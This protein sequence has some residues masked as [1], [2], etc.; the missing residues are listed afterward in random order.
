MLSDLLDVAVIVFAVTSMFSVGV[1]YTLR[2]IVGPLRSL[3]LVALSLVA[4]FLLV[5][6]WAVLLTWLLQ[7]DEPYAI[8][9]LLVSTAAGPHSSSNSWSC[10]TATSRS[11]GHCS[12]CS[13]R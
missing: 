4:N 8:G 11:P 13:C 3:R 12:C 5:P 1:T 6:A 10:Q 9:I 2:Q 7:L